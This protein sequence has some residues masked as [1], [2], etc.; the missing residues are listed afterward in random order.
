MVVKNTTRTLFRRRKRFTIKKRFW[1]FLSV[2]LVIAGTAF[3]F[4]RKSVVEIQNNKT[5]E[6]PSPSVS[7]T[8][9]VVPNFQE[10]GL[11]VP[12]PGGVPLPSPRA[13]KT[14]QPSATAKALPVSQPSEIPSSMPLPAGSPSSSPEPSQT[15]APSP[16]PSSSA[17]LSSASAI[18]WTNKYRAQNGLSAL[19]ENSKLSAAALAKAQ[20]MAENGYFNHLSPD[21]VSPSTLVKNYGYNFQATSENI[22]YGVFQSSQDL[23]AGWMDSAGHRANILN[24]DFKDIG[25]AIVKGIYQGREVWFAVQEFGCEFE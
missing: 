19:K 21:G 16:S 10:P 5:A 11:V 15:P 1:V 13:S 12:E 4:T 2:I 3:Y 23:I 14:P 9:S 18:E 22:A 6:S 20:D 24:K 7:S 25:L 8:P 17:V